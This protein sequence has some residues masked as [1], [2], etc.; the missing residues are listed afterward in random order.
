VDTTTVLS[1]GECPLGL[2][3]FVQRQRRMDQVRG[4]AAFTQLHAK[5]L[6]QPSGVAEDQPL[7]PR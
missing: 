4:D 7:L 1:L 5:L 6:D 3:P 2:L